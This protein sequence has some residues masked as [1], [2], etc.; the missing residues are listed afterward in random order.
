MVCTSTFHSVVFIQLFQGCQFLPFRFLPVRQKQFLPGWQKQV[1]ANILAEMAETQ[2]MIFFKICSLL[3]NA[4]D[5]MLL[6]VS[7]LYS[8]YCYVNPC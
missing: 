6:A 5:C 3:M 4:I 1:S 2:N 7:Y 8:M